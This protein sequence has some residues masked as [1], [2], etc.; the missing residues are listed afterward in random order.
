MRITLENIPRTTTIDR[1]E[2]AITTQSIEAT[3]Q[4]TTTIGNQTRLF[5]FSQK[6]Q[7]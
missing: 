1:P 5:L 3:T 2:F 6:M 7:V 4:L